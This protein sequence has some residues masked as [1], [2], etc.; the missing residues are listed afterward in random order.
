MDRTSAAEIDDT[1]EIALDVSAPEIPESAAPTRQRVATNGRVATLPKAHTASPPAAPPPAAPPAAPPKT[2]PAPPPAPAP[3]AAKGWGLSLAVLIAGMFMSILDISI[4]NVA[5][6]SIQKDLGAGDDIQWISTVYSLTEGVIVPASAWLGARFGLTRVYIWALALFTVA[7]ALCGMALSLESLIAF[8]AVQAIPGGVIPV[9]CLTILYRIVPRE[10]LGA[11]MGMY[12]VGIAVAPALGPALGGYLVEHLSWR[13]IFFINLPVGIVGAIAAMA[14][15]TKFPGDRSRPFDVPGFLCIAGSLFS[16]LL[17]LEEGSDWGWTSYPII[18]LFLAAATLMALFIVV[19]LE[20]KH[21]VLNIRVFKTWTYVNSL[22]LMAAMSVGLFVVMLYVPLFL[23]NVQ[24]LGAWDAGIL[25]LP[26]ALMMGFMMP[27]AGQLYDRIGARWPAFFG[28]LLTGTGMLLLSRINVDIPHGGIVLGMVI[29]TA[30]LGLGMIPIMTGGLSSLPSNV[31]DS[32]SAINTLTQRVSAAL[33]LAIITALMTSNRAQ[34]SADRYGLPMGASINAT[35]GNLQSSALPV[36]M[37][38]SNQVQTQAYSNA[39]LLVGIVA[40]AGST[41]AFFL[42]SK[43]PGSGGGG[44][45][46][47][48]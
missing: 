7:S 22:M 18:M 26:Q 44:A 19:E 2:P 9:V 16:L 29:I 48:H 21:P 40:I 1:A 3:P 36:Y 17:A 33:G 10:K 37:Q 31:A 24:G 30:G 13:T 28:L 47:M 27:I 20:V 41:L 46:A 15:L 8:R 14:V 34:L 11:A 35:P 12:G 4:V 6:S 45:A 38:L 25:L 5:M 42:P 23:Q 32:G 43:R 39:F